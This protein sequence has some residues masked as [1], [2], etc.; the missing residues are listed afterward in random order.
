[1]VLEPDGASLPAPRSKQLSIRISDT[2]LACLAS[3]R[4]HYGL[5][6]TAL[7]EFLLR[8]EA[9]RVAAQPVQP[10]VLPSPDV[11]EQ[12]DDVQRF[13]QQVAQQNRID[14]QRAESR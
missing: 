9:R 3:L 4:L 8:Q 14:R 11:D 6:K 10:F 2:A 5:S 12:D 1:M 13:G 7:L